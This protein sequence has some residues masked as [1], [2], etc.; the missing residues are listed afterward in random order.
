MPHRWCES[1]NLRR[2]Q[3]ESGLDLTFVEVFQPQFAQWVAELGP[4]RVI[5]IG[6]GTGHL[7]KSLEESAFSITA[8]EPSPG[9]HS[10]AEDVLKGTGVSLINCSSFDLPVTSTFD[11]ALSHL[12]AHVVADLPGF[13]KSVAVHVEEAGHFVFSIPHPCFYNAYKQ[14]FG[15]EYNYMSLLEKTVSFSV[16]K[17]PSNIISGVP[18]YHRP[19]SFYFNKIVEAGFAVDG[20]NEIYPPTEVQQKYGKLWESPRYCVFRCRKL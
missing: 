19:I 2:D 20:I 8:I 7:A 14:F 6:A 16:T 4:E 15:E 1:A 13:L 12:V 10:V 9:M 18:Y 3:I 17:D 11:L 5:E